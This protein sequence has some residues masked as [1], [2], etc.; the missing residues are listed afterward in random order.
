MSS[1]R[2]LTPRHLPISLV[3]NFCPYGDYRALT[4]LLSGLLA[5]SIAPALNVRYIKRM[6]ARKT[7]QWLREPRQTQGH[8][9]LNFMANHLRSSLALIGLAMT[10]LFVNLSFQQ[11]LPAR[12]SDLFINLAASSATIVIT[13]LIFETLQQRRDAIAKRPSEIMA[14]DRIER[15]ISVLVGCLRYFLLA[16][17]PDSPDSY[18]N[19]YR[20]P[21]GMYVSQFSW[22]IRL[23][24]LS[25]M[26]ALPD[27]ELIKLTR[28]S[29]MLIY[30]ELIN[31]AQVTDRVIAMYENFIDLNTLQ[32]YLG[33]SHGLHN[34][35]GVERGALFH[36]SS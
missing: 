17:T 32:E 36:C 4:T 9:V 21:K 19:E 12:V 30:D 25:R 6:S 11:N 18:P 23:H 10:G 3:T 7:K 33:I 31:S 13:V 15:R 29:L 27:T 22:G 35:W 1:V 2:M 20:N 8:K 26:R 34:V 14:F 16:N 24:E 28:E 5:E